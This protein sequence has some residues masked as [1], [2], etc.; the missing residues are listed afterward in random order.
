MKTK[1]KTKLIDFSRH[2]CDEVAQT[3]KQD[4]NM[5]LSASRPLA[6][7]TAFRQ[8]LKNTS[9]FL[10]VDLDRIGTF[11]NKYTHF[12][13]NLVARNK[14]DLKP[15]PNGIFLSSYVKNNIT[16]I[17][18]FSPLTNLNMCPAINGNNARLSHDSHISSPD[19]NTIVNVCHNSGESVK[20]KDEVTLQPYEFTTNS[21]HS[22]H[23]TKGNHF[24]SYCHDYRSFDI[25]SH[26]NCNVPLASL[27]SPTITTG[28]MPKRNVLWPYIPWI[29]TKLITIY[30]PGGFFIFDPGGS[31][32]WIT[33]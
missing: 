20:N 26:E 13:L 24:P 29:M 32:S 16:Q 25:L 4:G 21:L 5:A 10:I 2:T 30:D 6:G 28:S 9:L 27:K 11:S 8:N 19:N 22:Y 14:S 3:A 23:M 17:L 1:A 33:L 15:Q 12:P 18:G 7:V 31:Y